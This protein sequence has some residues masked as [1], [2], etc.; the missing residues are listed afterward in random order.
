MLKTLLIT[1]SK[2]YTKSAESRSAI[3]RLTQQ[4]AKPEGSESRI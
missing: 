1:E 2:T 3:E 4:E